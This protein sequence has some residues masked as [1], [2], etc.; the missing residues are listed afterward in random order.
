MKVIFYTVIAI[1][2]ILITF[3]GLGPVLL[4]DGSMGERM[5]TL[6]VVLLLYL[7][8]GGMATA[9]TKWYKRRNN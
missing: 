5:G 2:F 4:A 7:I 6:A 9:F 8:L 1:I 3:F